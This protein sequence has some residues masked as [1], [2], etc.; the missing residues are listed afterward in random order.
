MHSGGRFVLGTTLSG[1]IFGI[2]A[3]IA[4]VASASQLT[5]IAASTTLAQNSEQ[6]T[7]SAA[8]TIEDNEYRFALQKCQR[9]SKIV[10]C[11]LIITNLADED[12]QLNLY[13]NH[14]Y[15]D[16]PRPQIVDYSGNQY[17]IKE[18]QI[19]NKRSNGYEVE[20]RLI[21]GIPVKASVSF[22][23]PRQVNKLAVFEVV[24]RKAGVLI[25]STPFSQVQFRDV[26]IITSKPSSTRSTG[27]VNKK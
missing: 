20:S 26:D 27:T 22:E 16:V 1:L 18:V 17:V 24:A 8:Q 12:R 25:Y 9:V 3:A 19:G 4:T 5:A 2:L 7:S 10:T 15:G 14:N 11:Y 21:R 6:E 13:G 23:L